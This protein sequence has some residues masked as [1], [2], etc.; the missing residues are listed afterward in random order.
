MSNSVQ[1]RNVLV[2]ACGQG[3]VMTGTVM[4]TI[5]ASLAG[6]LLADDPGLATLPMALQMTAT[7]L[8]ATPASLIMSKIGRRA[9]FTIGQII[10]I[11]GGLIAVYSLLYAQSFALLCLAGFFIGSHIAF[12]Q[13]SRFAVVDASDEDFRPRA[14]S[15]VLTGGVLA[16]LVGPEIAK[17]SVD[18]FSPVLYA[19]TYLAFCA[20][21]VLNIITVQFLKLPKPTANTNFRAGRPMGEIARQPT[22]LL[23]LFASMIGYSMMVLVMTATPLSMQASGFDF[24]DT[25]YVIQWHVIFM[26]APGFFTGNLIKKFGVTAIIMTGTFLIMLSMAASLSGLT[27]PH[28]WIALALIGVGWNFMFVGGTSLLIETYTAEERAKVQA[29]NDTLV[30]GTTAIASFSSGA[31]LN[32]LGWDAVNMAILAPCILLFAGAYLVRRKRHTVTA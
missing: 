6:I 32:W 12:W 8:M 24:S 22:F 14:I 7:M 10:G 21:G 30:F 25:A 5:V 20:M 1:Y 2:L 23:A 15:L 18:M 4:T 17:L 29:F 26:F 11:I 3:L 13:L 31:L 9:G 19:G 16:A 27:L 28:F